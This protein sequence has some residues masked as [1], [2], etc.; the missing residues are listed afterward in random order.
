MIVWQGLALTLTGVIVGLL[1]AG[2]LSRSIAGL[3]FSTSPFDV[4]TFGGTALLLALV[5]TA[6]YAVPARRA[7]K[8][9]PM[10]ALR[11]E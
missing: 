6:A 2:A 7:T 1:L 9:D 5:A 11:H 3:L 4:F 8:I 10:L